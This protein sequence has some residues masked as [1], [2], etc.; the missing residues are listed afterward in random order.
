MAA[1]GDF[2]ARWGQYALSAYR[3]ETGRYRFARIVSKHLSWSA[4]EARREQFR[5]LSHIVE[6]S[7]RHCSFY[8]ERFAAVGF[9]PGDLKDFSDLRRLP[10]LTRTDL[11]LHKNEI[12]SDSIPHN[13]MEKSLTGGTTGEALSFYRDRRCL[14]YRRGIDLA[15]ARYYG[16]QDGQWQGL[17]WAAPRDLVT[18]RGLKA[19]LAQ[20]WADRVYTLDCLRLSDAAYEEFV[21]KT[22]RYCPSFVLA[23]PS[24]AFDLA[25][26]IEA[27][28][29]SPVRIPVICVTAEP[30]Y[31]FQR[32]KIETVLADR[33]YARYGSREVGTAAFECHR[34][35]GLHIISESVYIE[36]VPAAGDAQLGVVLVTD[37]LNTAM[38]LIRYR[39]GDLGRLD[40]AACDCGLGTP[41]L[42]QIQGRET[43]IIW[44]PD[45]TGL[46]GTEIVGMVRLSCFRTKVQVVQEK[47][48]EIV[49]RIEDMSG[50]HH[51]NIQQLLECFRREIGADIHYRVEQVN[52]IERAPS[53]KYRYVISKVSRPEET[54]KDVLH[55]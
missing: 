7:F 54:E 27:G 22:K 32:K 55:T 2:M 25:E 50:Q 17:L 38:P 48:N 34:Q 43:D 15:L 46:P 44:R 3:K 29:V 36:I 10:E 14:D 53:G 42:L 26:R 41:R 1:I 33:V 37:L 23:Y 16:W 35:N 39:M 21:D 9:E 52:K 5:R 51:D 19:K 8:R 49:V 24:L 13:R 4:E 12:L 40:D 20:R 45:G 31:D 47:L 28:K 30:L 6:Y 18:R 11:R